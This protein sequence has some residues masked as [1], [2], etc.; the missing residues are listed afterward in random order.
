MDK[1]PACQ[2][3]EDYRPISST[4]GRGTTWLVCQNCG[5]IQDE[6][7]NVLDE[8]SIEIQQPRQAEMG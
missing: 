6:E 1:C 8:G 2:S 4:G 7:G 3:T 5:Y